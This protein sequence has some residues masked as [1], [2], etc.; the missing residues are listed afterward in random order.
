MIDYKLLESMWEQKR[1]FG[2][3]IGP[4]RRFFYPVKARSCRNCCFANFIDKYGIERNKQVGCT[5]FDTV[6]SKNKGKYG[7]RKPK[8]I[9]I[10]VRDDTMI[11]ELHMDSVGSWI[12]KNLHL[13]DT[14]DFSTSDHSDS[15]QGYPS[16]HI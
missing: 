8:N 9:C 2:I 3:L 13:N 7:Y 15:H 12:M 14:P 1:G 16:N 4:F 10:P 11:S 6:S 5:F